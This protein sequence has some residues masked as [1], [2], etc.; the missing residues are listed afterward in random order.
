MQVNPITS[1]NNREENNHPILTTFPH[2]AVATI[3][4][5]QV[6]EQSQFNTVTLSLKW[7]GVSHSDFLERQE[8]FSPQILKLFGNVKSIVKYL[9]LSLL[10]T[11]S[12]S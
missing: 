11:L 1:A 8:L 6:G 7:K 5:L 12:L 2:P 10:Y 4:V 3:L 9:S